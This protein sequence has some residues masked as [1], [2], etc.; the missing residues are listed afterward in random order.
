MVMTFKTCIFY[1]KISNANIELTEAVLP[2]ATLSKRERQN[3][4]KT[5]KQTNK[6]TNKRK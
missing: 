3:K 6:Q 2:E 1:I 5:N 4:Q